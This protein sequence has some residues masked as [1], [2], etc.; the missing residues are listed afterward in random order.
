MKLIVFKIF[1]F[2]LHATS[3]IL[4][5][6]ISGSQHFLAHGSTF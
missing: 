4:I 1:N 5:T 6:Q 3:P 2:S